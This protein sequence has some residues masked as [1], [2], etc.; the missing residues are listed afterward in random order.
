MASHTDLFN[1]ESLRE[2]PMNI[3]LRKKDY[4]RIQAFGGVT[5]FSLANGQ[6]IRGLSARE[7]VSALVSNWFWSHFSKKYTF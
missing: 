4:A 6:P 1:H 7:A 3:L 5:L 2:H